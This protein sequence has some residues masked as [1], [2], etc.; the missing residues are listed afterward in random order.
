MANSDVSL[1][2]DAGDEMVSRGKVGSFTK[3]KKVT[4]PKIVIFRKGSG[5]KK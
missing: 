2:S 4:K 3:A 1:S 5:P